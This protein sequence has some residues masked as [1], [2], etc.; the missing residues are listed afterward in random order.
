MIARHVHDDNFSCS[1]K[2]VIVVGYRWLEV[3]LALLQLAVRILN[4][5]HD[6]GLGD[7]DSRVRGCL[8]L[9]QLL[10]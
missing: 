9:V 10:Y 7:Q 6:S 4:D 3:T 5:E 8:H 1:G 2:A